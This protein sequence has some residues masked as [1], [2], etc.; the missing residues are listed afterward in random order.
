MENQ[1]NTG[2]QNA[3]QL[4]KKP[5][6]NYWMISTISLLIILLICGVWFISNI[7]S[8]TSSNQQ[9]AVSCPAG[10][11]VVTG[12]IRTSGLIK[13]EKQGSL[14]G[15]D[16]QVT[17]LIDDN[18]K[19]GL[20]GY[21]LKSDNNKEIEKLLGKCA[22]V[23]GKVAQGWEN[24]KKD[25]Y[26]RS[27][28]NLD[29]IKKIDFSN[30][31]TSIKIT[32]AIEPGQQKFKIKGILIYGKR[33]APDMG[34][35]Y[36]LKLTEFFE[37][38]LNSSGI[39]LVSVVDIISSGENIEN[40]I[41][42][43]VSMEGYID[44]GYSE[45]RYFT[46]L[47]IINIGFNEKA[48]IKHLI[49]LFEQKVQYAKQYM[50]YNN[51]NEVMSLFTPPVTKE[52]KEVY[53]SIMGLDGKGTEPRLFNNASSNYNLLSWKIAKRESSDKLE[54]I[55]KESKNK[56]LVVVE[57]NRRSP[58][59]VLGREVETSDFFVF[60]IVKRDLQWMIDKYYW[61]SADTEQIEPLKY[62]GFG[63]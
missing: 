38:K 31:D 42:N 39:P 20:Q 28:L 51:I 48:E 15:L 45:S 26:S 22:K 3:Q 8:M 29:E 60:E 25:V 59:P 35:D 55:S 57:E 24:A 37:D 11:T 27:I 47:K 52:E 9:Q 17:G 30:C 49:A 61:Q 14:A 58:N 12:I 43:E 16:F 19:N 62:R 44:W 23:T 1:I 32:P 6:V 18:L 40:N 54:Q 10:Q 53:G 4:L 7:K 2:D 36:Q 5:K 13:E 21:Y 56:Y 63:F 41:N 34:Y 33:L 50:N 46:P